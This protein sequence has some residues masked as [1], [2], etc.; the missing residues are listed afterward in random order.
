MAQGGTIIRLLA[1]ASALGPC[2]CMGGKHLW[3]RDTK[4]A[5]PASGEI[6]QVGHAE[7][8][9]DAADEDIA[10]ERRVA[11]ADVVVRVCQRPLTVRQRIVL[12]RG[13]RDGV[14]AIA[15]HPRVESLS[16]G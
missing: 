11:V 16:F 15:A 13:A 4:P 12:Q 7:L 5:K 1:V 14:D 8:M 3:T 2:G 6:T 9:I 10:I